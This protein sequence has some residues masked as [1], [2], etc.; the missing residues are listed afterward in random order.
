[1]EKKRISK[2]TNVVS[3]VVKYIKNILIPKTNTVLDATSAKGN[4]TDVHNLCVSF[5]I[6][7]INLLLVVLKKKL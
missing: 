7:D 3:L 5:I 6:K 1:M 2:I 4:N